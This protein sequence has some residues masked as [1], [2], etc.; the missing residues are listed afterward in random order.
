MKFPFI[1][2]RVGLATVC[3]AR[4]I[5]PVSVMSDANNAMLNY[6][7]KE[8]DID[9]YLLGGKIQHFPFSSSESALKYLIFDSVEGLS[10]RCL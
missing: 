3:T 4:R 5:Q 6:G 2:E 1:T 9:I 10:F 7:N 8:S